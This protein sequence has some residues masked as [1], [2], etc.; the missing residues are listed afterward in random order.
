MI[1]FRFFDKDVTSKVLKIEKNF[2]WNKIKFQI[3]KKFFI[4]IYINLFIKMKQ[5]YKLKIFL[6]S[7]L[8]FCF[9]VKGCAFLIYIY[10]Y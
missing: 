7:E 4:F 5:K 10:L 6:W 1:H 2:N 9:D 8:N 3:Q